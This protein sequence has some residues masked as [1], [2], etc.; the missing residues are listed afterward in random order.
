MSKSAPPSAPGVIR[1]LDRPD[2]VRRKINRAV[3]DSE[4]V[5]RFDPER[6]PGVSNLID[7]IAAVSGDSVDDVAGAVA[8]YGALK[9]ACIDCVNAALEPIQRTHAELM[10]EP[11]EL[12]ALLA[13]GAERASAQ[14]EP[15]LARAREAIG[16]VPAG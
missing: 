15:V 14:A 7:I 10:A 13:A 4:T 2:V 9:A 6:K 5:V 3:T 16:L 11:G 1:M 12:N 8:S